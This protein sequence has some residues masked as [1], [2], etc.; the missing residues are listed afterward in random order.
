[1]LVALYGKK[2][3]LLVERGVALPSNL[4]GL[5]RC[6]FE[7]DKLEYDSTQKLLK[8]TSNNDNFVVGST[9]AVA[10]RLFSLLI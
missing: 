10:R 8:G 7:G 5:N 3:F 4:Q 2:V 9:T 6:D 1:M